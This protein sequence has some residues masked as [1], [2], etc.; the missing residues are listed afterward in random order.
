MQKLPTAPEQFS[1][2]H[3]NPPDPLHYLDTYSAAD[4][5]QAY[6]RLSY[7]LLQVLPG[8]HIL[9][10]GC[11][12]GDDVRALAQL[13]GAS[14]KV[15]G[16]DHNERM[17]SE[18]RQRAENTGLPVEF[19]LCDVASLPFEQHT[20]NACRADRIFQ[21]LEN[22]QRALTEI[23]RVAKPGARIL[24][25]EPD[26]ET[27]VVDLPDRSTTRKIANFICDRILR[28]GWIG[29]QLPN[30]FR[31]CGCEEIGVTAN[32]VP[33]TD[34]SLADFLWGLRRNAERACD[35]GVVSESEMKSWSESLEQASQ[36]HRFFG[37]VTGFA[38][39]GTKP[40][41]GP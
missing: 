38:V 20:F 4:F 2:D 6:K 1:V 9:D 40:E 21:H 10:V 28:N 18:A 15:I 33:L 30:L 41:A 19:Y 16:I 7:E 36:A 3:S 31:I 5:A 39:C 29:R 23:I 11:G 37:A 22:P 13:V 32:A 12:P 24:V 25:M 34:F 27:L 35:A 14:G 17:I 8:Y 26:W